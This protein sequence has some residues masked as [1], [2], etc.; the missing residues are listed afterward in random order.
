MS[1]PRYA[2]L[3][4]AILSRVS[5]VP[6]P[7]PDAD[8]RAQAITAI[9]EAIATAQRRR[10]LRQWSGGCAAAAVIVLSAVTGHRLAAK[11]GPVA[12]APATT[13]D[14]VAQIVAHPVSGGSS[15]VVSG[16]QAPLDDG[17]LLGP[18]SRVV[19]PANGS[20]MLSFSTGST[21]LLRERTDMTIAAEGLTQTLHLDVGSVELHVAKLAP[22]HR[23]IV[24]TPD[25]EVEVRGTRFTVSIVAPDPGCG[26]GSRTRV[27]VA[28]GVVAVRHDGTED[29]VT[30]GEQW[31]RGC[32]RATAASIAGPRPTNGPPVA[33]ATSSGSTL[34]D[35]NDLFATAAA[36]KRRGDARGAVAAL[37]RFL[38]MYPA[39]PL[40]ESASAERMRILRTLGRGR[41]LAA[42]KEYLAR[43]PNGFA[44]SEAEAIAAESP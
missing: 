14:A 3:A 4:S 15:V 44:H 7:A 41:S 40:T 6:P 39:S 21:A 36:A 9:A 23:F 38:A 35:Q 17:R 27:V 43:Y 34:A 16:A 31:P 20:A 12:L 10:R 25:S 28:E 1:A 24:A 29:R 2:R 13:E 22:D 18:G 42:A 5:S 33:I 26:A 30:M 32:Q 19:T 8:D 11:P 37:D